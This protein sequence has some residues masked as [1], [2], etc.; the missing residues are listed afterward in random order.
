MTTGGPSTQL[1]AFH[2]DP[3]IKQ[4][5]VRRVQAHRKADELIKGKYW[6]NGKGCAV[7]CTIHGSD[8]AA[9]EYKLGIPRILA[10][11]EDSIFEFLPNGKAQQWPEQFLDSIRVG[12]DLSLVWPKFA[13]W[14]LTDA[15]NGVLQFAKNERSRNAIQAVADAYTKV[16][17]SKGQGIDWQK[18]R[19][20]AAADAAVAAAYA[21]VAAA[22]TAAA[23][24][25]TAAADAADAAAAYAADTSAAYAADTS[26]AYAA[27]AADAARIAQSEK[28]LELLAAA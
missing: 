19:A 23:Y 20:V 7:G 6:E 21:A 28:L 22:D 13:V 1:L 14:L 5:Y 10:R 12:A 9:Y 16:I 26:A 27:V 11:L 8:H 24:A 25:D 15:K 17:E 2:G 18:L 3:V 4:K